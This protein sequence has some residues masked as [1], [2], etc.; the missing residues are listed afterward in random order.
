MLEPTMAAPMMTTS[1]VCMVVWNRGCGPAS[2][3][4]IIALRATPDEGVRGYTSAPQPSILARGAPLV[5]ALSG[6]GGVARPG[7]VPIR[8]STSVILPGLPAP[9][10]LERDGSALPLVLFR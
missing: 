8:C 10:S 3:P 4:K 9:P 5:H 2:E 7:I 1:A 6:M